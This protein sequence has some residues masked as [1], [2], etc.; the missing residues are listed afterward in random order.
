MSA[1]RGE[2]AQQRGQPRRLSGRRAEAVTQADAR[3]GAVN[4]AASGANRGAWRS[5]AR[6]RTPASDPSAAERPERAERGDRHGVRS[7]CTR[8]SG[9][10]R[11][12][13]AQAAMAKAAAGVGA[14]AVARRSAAKVTQRARKAQRD[15]GVGAAID[16]TDAAN[17]PGAESS[18]ITAPTPARSLSAA[19][20]VPARTAKLRRSGRLGEALSARSEVP[21]AAGAAGRRR[22]GGV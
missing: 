18:G 13:E 1:E 14:G 15:E 10:V 7:A 3:A 9:R 5:P 17:E 22:A 11:T 19:S 8:R 4:A 2:R 6:A 20:A 16:E 12:V 21:A